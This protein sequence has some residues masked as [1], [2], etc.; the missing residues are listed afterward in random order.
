MLNKISPIPLYYQLAESLRD[1]I[2]SGRL[3][4]GDQ[5]PSERELAEQY[6]ISRMTV[7]QALQHLIRDE[8]LVARQGLGTY[9]AEPKLTVDPLHVLGFTDEMIRRGANTRSQ[10]IE[11]ALVVAP[12]RVAQRLALADGAQ[13]VKL[14]RLRFS[15]G[16]PMLLEI[17]YVP[18]QLCPG[19]ETEDLSHQSLYQTLRERFSVQPAGAHHTF[20]ASQATEYEAELFGM[21]LSAPMII[22]QGVTYDQDDQ[23]IEDFK[24][25]YRGD[26]FAIVIDSRAAASPNIGAPQLSMVMR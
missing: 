4:T 23:P 7:R 26:R 3:A 12:K 9:V 14:V 6:G 18:A 21:S 19:L 1:Q 11:Q 2:A 24:A 22:L 13:V 17:V 5:L 15:D 25:V 16:E 20:E 10:V 8:V